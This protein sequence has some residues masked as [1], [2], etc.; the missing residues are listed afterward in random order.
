MPAETIGLSATLFLYRDQVRIMT[1]RHDVSHLRHPHNGVSTLPK[2]ATSALAAVS[3]RRAKLYYQRQRLLEVGPSAGAFL[4]ELV[5]ARPYT[6][7]AD[8]RQL[9]DLLLK[10]GPERM[11]GAFQQAV[12]R[13]WHGAELVEPLLTR[14]WGVLEEK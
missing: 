13:G 12:D 14:P 7:A 11:V 1:D 6:W 3:G 8:V 5:H 9:F 4:T 10:H 2:H